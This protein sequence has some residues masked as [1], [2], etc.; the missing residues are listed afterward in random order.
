MNTPTA[1]S[2]PRCG[3]PL[4]TGHAGGN[5][6]ACLLQS[7]L[8][9]D[10]EPFDP[11]FDRSP[12]DAV[13][14]EIGGFEILGEIG[15]GGTGIVF[16]AVQHPVNRIVALKTL[17]GAA[18]SRREEF[19]R[20]RIEAEA[21]GRL[22]H[23]HIVPLYEVGRHAG[24]PFLTLRYF[25]KGSLADALRSRRFA[26]R[27][28]ARL[29]ATAARALNHA[30]QRGVLHRDIKPSNLLLDA[31]DTPHVADFGL[32]KLAGRDSEL[33]LSTSVLG[34][35]S[36]MAPEQAGG[37]AREAGVPADVYGL[38]AILYELLT[39]HPPFTGASALEVLRR[40]VDD[41][42][43]PIR[44]K[45]PGVDADLEA[46][47]LRCLEK[48][49][50]RR[51]ETAGALADDLERWQRGEPV[52]ARPS[53]LPLRTLRWVRRR[54]LV[55]ALIATVALAV[56]GGIAATVRQ[57][58]VALAE[59]E[60]ALGLSY[61]AAL[62][63]AE[64]SIETGNLSAAR[65][66]LLQQPDRF[67]GLE[68][69]RLMAKAHTLH[70]SV[71]VLT[72]DWL[73]Q[74]YTPVWG[75]LSEDG[76]W[77]AAGSTGRLEVVDLPASR[78][79]LQLGTPTQPVTA[80]SF[81]PDGRI[82]GVAGPGPGYRLLECGSWKELA[83]LE[84]T[85]SRSR[86]IH[87]SGDGKALL[88]AAE[89]TPVTVRSAR[90]FSVLFQLPAEAGRV[91][92]WAGFSGS[93]RRILARSR[94]SDG[95]YRWHVWEAAD[96]TPVD[97]FPEADRRFLSVEF[98][99]DGTAYA[100]VE[101]EGFAS[102]WDVGAR[103]PRF[104]AEPEGSPA[105]IG[106]AA[107]SDDG[108]R[109][110]TLM[111]SPGRLTFWN[112][113]SGLR[114]PASLKPA[115]AVGRGG[116][117]AGLVSSAYDRLL[118]VWDWSSGLPLEALPTDDIITGAQLMRSGNGHWVGA[119][120]RTVAGPP[121]VLAW[122]L[123]T[124]DLR[125]RTEYPLVAAAA[126]PA[127]THIASGSKDAD[128]WLW[129]ADSGRRER[130]LPGHQ[131]CVSAVAW[132]A[133][134]RSLFSTGAD[135]RIHRWRMP[136]ATIERSFH[137]LVG[138]GWA[139][140]ITPDGSRLAAC[141]SG[142]VGVWDGNSGRKLLELAVSTNRMPW[143][144]RFSPDG[145]RLAVSGGVELGGVFDVSSGE[146]VY[147]FLPPG[148]PPEQSHISAA[149]SPDGR[150]LA[151]VR[152]DGWLE[153]RE[154]RSWS[155]I[156]RSRIRSVSA[157]GIQF[158]PDGN[159]L[160]LLTAESS[161]GSGVAAIEV[162]D[163]STGESLVVLDRREGTGWSLALD[164]S[165][166][167]IQRTTLGW[168]PA[169]CGAEFHRILPW[170]D[171]DLLRLGNGDIE[172]GLRKA[173][174]AL[175]ER[176]WQNAWK[177]APDAPEPPWRE[178][179]AFWP[180]RS[181]AT[182]ATCIDLTE[183]YNGHLDSGWIPA[184]AYEGHEDTLHKLPKGIQQ[185]D[186]VTWDIRGV[187]STGRVGKQPFIRWRVGREVLGIPIH[188]TARRLHFLHAA[189]FGN[190]VG[191]RAGTYR[192]H[193]ADGSTADLPLLAGRDIGEWWDGFQF[194]RCDAG[195]I[196]WESTTSWSSRNG[197]NV[198][199][200]HRAWDNPHPDREIRSIDLIAEGYAVIPFVVAITVEP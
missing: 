48:E 97:V 182:P 29:V 79:V 89:G 164:P 186:G 72:N 77:I 4:P 137:G 14:P 64:N 112:L 193:Y 90:D 155:V 87:F 200:Y 24:T 105:W 184:E 66:R 160:V 26:P 100:A 150:R 144:V 41:E 44:P 63:F 18:L 170:R 128:V 92:E 34:T 11:D 49:P 69:G 108:T 171:A 152:L 74:E 33:T 149:F 46:V 86:T 121:R 50:A 2:C 6:P 177:A 148:A 123:P 58:R 37:R 132:T 10:P 156:A 176:R 70:R 188:R 53:T 168:D 167:F 68:W 119:V 65:E 23:P 174:A 82:L 101:P 117:N 59:R 180:A 178:D 162:C 62:E 122:G 136:E 183:A 8:L 54:P 71:P 175:H 27:E 181:P 166:Q 113:E 28:A 15:R 190:H 106:W 172:A 140:D 98:N 35:P 13:P 19:E 20:L 60:V 80:A 147:A 30:H 158:T 173:A 198:R 130:F 189:H 99:T 151:S 111:H 196:A 153:I 36:Y 114:M 104:R 133:D 138:P 143:L 42:P 61:R 75:A 135:G 83:H 107:L 109:M 52:Q 165:L 16:K 124:Q 163:G 1:P 7:A 40:V 139:L 88:T 43:A 185:L 194:S 142:R 3:K 199:L 32:A 39:G 161:Q 81:H 96:G 102:A 192:L 127:G 191:E 94:A 47:C 197:H 38:G 115:R 110:A 57:T 120:I 5:C 103:Q 141:T 22:E 56:L 169:L 67:R 21:V 85:E 93:G 126:N 25:E 154:T 31:D 76:R 95:R 145:Q 131:W 159:R 78:S 146:R 118:Q 125:L 9:D 12:S 17:N 129:N 84:P 73:D 134:G 116:P 157:A 45:S 195:S 51:Y 187:V 55:S 179:R 91:F